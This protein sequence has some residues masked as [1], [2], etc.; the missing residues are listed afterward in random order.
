MELET[1]HDREFY[2]AKAKRYE[3]LE[4][5]LSGE[6]S[7]SGHLEETISRLIDEPSQ[8]AF[9]S[10]KG[11]TTLMMEFTSGG[12]DGYNSRAHC[13]AN[14][15]LKKLQLKSLA[16]LFI[17]TAVALFVP[18]LAPTA[19][20][21]LSLGGLASTLVLPESLSAWKG[22]T[23]PEKVFAPLYGLAEEMDQDIGRC[24]IIEHHPNAKP[25]FEE[26]YRLLSGD[27]REEID[28]Q[29][30]S[31]LGAGGMPDMDDIQLNSYLSGLLTP[32][33]EGDA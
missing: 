33:V 12:V 21:Y 7:I 6:M 22:R 30:H 23:N 32:Q 17:T 9:D 15:R 29:L 1:M 28:A 31:Y 16:T 3:Q 18:P 5:A 25:F 27:E 4:K 24:F 8:K 19:A 26:T 11:L 20:F 13:M 14:W 2:E 10:F